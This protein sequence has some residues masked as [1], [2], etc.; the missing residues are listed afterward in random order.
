ME[1]LGWLG[2]GIVLCAVIGV[3]LWR[4]AKRAGVEQTARDVQ[5][6]TDIA[7]EEIE[8]HAQETRDRGVTDDRYLD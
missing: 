8:R 2:G 7:T 4:T 1:E 3:A 6:S 5:R